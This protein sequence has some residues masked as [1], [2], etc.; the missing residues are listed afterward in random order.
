MLL[1]IARL[2][3]RVLR[4]PLPRVVDAVVDRLLDAVF[5]RLMRRAERLEHPNRRRRRLLAEKDR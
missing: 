5:A 4:L 1:L 3:D 2:L